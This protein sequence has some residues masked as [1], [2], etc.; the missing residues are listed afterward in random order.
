MNFAPRSSSGWWVRWSCG[1][2]GYGFFWRWRWGRSL[3]RGRCSLWRRHVRRRRGG[4][5]SAP[6][7]EERGRRQRLCEG[8]VSSFQSYLYWWQAA[9][10]PREYCAALQCSS[11][12][13][14]CIVSRRNPRLTSCSAGCSGAWMRYTASSAGLREKSAATSAAI[15]PTLII[16]R[17]L[18]WHQ[19]GAEAQLW[20]AGDWP[21]YGAGYFLSRATIRP[22]GDRQGADTGSQCWCF[23]RGWAAAW[24]VWA[25]GG[26][27]S[28]A[29]PSP[30]VTGD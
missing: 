25:C 21:G 3:R 30:I 10:R 6:W 22:A 1:A 9:R 2:F 29:V 24:G 27:C 20:P 13:A 7:R 28:A 11:G 17:C 5:P 4:V 26:A 14:D 8:G 19:G 15:L 16:V 23:L 12:S 18:H